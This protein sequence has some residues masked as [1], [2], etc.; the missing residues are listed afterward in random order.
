[1]NAQGRDR[2]FGTILVLVGLGLFLNAVDVIRF[3]TIETGVWIALS[4]CGLLLMIRGWKR[5]GSAVLFIGAFFFVAG[6]HAVLWTLGVLDV[7]GEGAV[8]AFFLWLGLA[9]VF[10]WLPTPHKL[11][12]LIPAFL[13]GGAGLGYYLWWY[14]LY[15]WRE[16]QDAY[17]SGWPVF[18][19]L[20]GGGIVFRSIRRSSN[21]VP[22]T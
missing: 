16:I 14:D 12:L 7:D 3:E 2:L 10:M 22:K 21:T 9:S 11:D 15:R 6:I 20:L 19:I 13:F 1:M 5:K 18:L 17:E 8:A 4:T